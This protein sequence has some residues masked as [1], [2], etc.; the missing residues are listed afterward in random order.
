MTQQKKG[1]EQALESAKTGGQPMQKPEEDPA[2]EALVSE[3]TELMQSG[4]MPEGF[5]LQASLKDEALVELMQDYG[6][7][8]GI[9]IYIAEKRA[10]AAEESA[11][12]RVSERVRARSAVPRSTRAGG[13][14]GA[15]TVNY[16]AMTGAEFRRVLQQMKDTAR[17]GGK[18][19]L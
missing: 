2:F 10:D 3:L 19:R 13:S 5:D 6:A 8:A 11:M 15:S 9:R 1:I 16:R 7:A 18:T 4:A 14:A 17:D 12:Q